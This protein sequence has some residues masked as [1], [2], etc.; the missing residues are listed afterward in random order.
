MLG[1]RFSEAVT[2][3]GEAL[4]IAHV[5]GARDIEGHALDTR[6]LSRSIGGEVDEGLEDLRAALAIAEELDIV[7]DVGRAYANMVWVIDAAGRLDEAI[8]LA[9]VA[10]AKAER[11]GLM[12]FFGTHMLAGQADALFRL[13][14][15][16]ES[17]RA[18]RR[19]EE[20]GPLGINEI[21]TEE[22]IGRLA[23]ARGRLE[24]AA[25]HL[26]PLAPLAARAEDIQFIE[27]VNST[28]ASLALAEGRPEDAAAIVA[29]A[30]RQID[31][32]PEVRIGEL[33]AL[34]LRANADAAEIAR[35]RRGADRERA[36]AEAG[37]AL[38]EAIRRR[39]AEV[40]AT[41]SVFAPLSSAWLL[42]CE[43]EATRL[44]RRAE[45]EAWVASGDAWRKLERPYMVAYARLREAE[46]RLAARGDRALAATALRS[47]LDTAERLGAEP[48]RAEIMALA[49]RAR[50]SVDA[51]AA[52]DDVVPAAPDEASRLGLT[53]REREVLALVALGRTN[54]QIAEELFISE[55]T[56][57]VHVSN[58]L[59]KLAVTGRGEAA[60][61]AYRLGL[62]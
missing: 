25:D 38:L 61:I 60:A 19:A 32:T 58:I 52:A 53:A 62:A 35:A 54:R 50:L 15:W 22:L 20:V 56:A 44:H 3:A 27:P 55:N 41:R 47:A 11:L 34:G 48:L 57:G 28:L 9:D 33:Y 42:L 45:P 24:E 21:L 14:R 49:T 10:I 37:D 30:I 46:A 31:H 26:L 1:G 6:G 8:E 51:D 43:A 36:A 29:A 39:H 59:G 23:L 2:L 7:D 40:A 5:V 18:I 4:T 16:D 17:E 12:R 13:G